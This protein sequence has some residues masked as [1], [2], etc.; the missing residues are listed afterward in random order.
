MVS[1]DTVR[2]AQ[3]I[4][5][6]LTF[7][8]RLGLSRKLVSNTDSLTRRRLCFYCASLSPKERP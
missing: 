4:G 8:L 5:V 3:A 2:L 6:T 1:T 7:T